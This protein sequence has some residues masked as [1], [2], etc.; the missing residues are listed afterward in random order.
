MP[1]FA[2]QLRLCIGMVLNGDQDLLSLVA[3]EC[4]SFIHLNS[5][6][7]KRSDAMPDGD[8][9]VPSVW[10]ANGLGLAAR[11]CLIMLLLVLM[12]YTFLLEQP[13]SSVLMKTKRMQW[14]TEVLASY[15]IWI[16]K[17][18]FW[19]SGW[20]HSNPKRTVLWSNSP[21]VRVF[22]TPKVAFSKCKG[23]PTAVRY[24][25]KKTGEVGYTGSKHLKDTEHLASILALYS[26]LSWF[27]S[28]TR[29]P[30][31]HPRIFGVPQALPF[32]VC[33]QS[34]GDHSG[35]FPFRS[36]NEDSS[37]GHIPS[38]FWTSSL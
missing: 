30:H 6:T 25:S 37:R 28:F 38:W 1:L 19:M 24:V 26:I 12:G 8:P 29:M 9:S 20:G 32:E 10:N 16:F 33:S 3:T 2:L 23:P 17:Q 21:V 4:S 14:L 15:G 5:G 18:A 35:L 36:A 11:S 22:T 31:R 13:G 27:P 7:S 34:G